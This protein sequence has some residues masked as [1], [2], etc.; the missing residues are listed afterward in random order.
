MNQNTKNKHLTLQDRI[1]IQEC[2]S[3]NISFKTIA[4]RIGKSPTT[5]SR[6]IKSH[7]QVQ[8]NSFVKTDEICPKLIKAPFVCNGCKKR[9]HSNCQFKRQV[10]IAKKAHS[11]YEYL[12]S[13]ARS[14]I[15]L[16]KES[17]YE[18]ERIISNAVKKGQ[19]VYHAIQTNN[20][21][22]ST[23]TVY[24]HIKMGYYTISSID[25]PR[26]VRFK[27]RHKK[28]AEFV[29]NCVKQGRTYQ[30][31]LDYTEKNS[32]LPI[33]QLDTVI[34][35]I[36][37]KVIMTIHF[38][39]CD[40]MTGL[41]LD[42]KTAA[43][44]TRKITDL[45]VHLEHN[46]FCFGDIIPVILTDNGGEFSN[47]LAFENDPNG[48]QETHLFYCNPNASYEKPE[49]EKNHTLLRDIVPKG[50]SFDDFTQENINMIFSHINAVK[51][52]QFNG[53]SAYDIFTFYYSAEL[54]SALG[55]SFVSPEDVI[56]SSKL[57]KNL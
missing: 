30:D 36:G 20:L 54:A 44:A 48:C 50:S 34:G 22:V 2:L 7:L 38:V 1:E 6:E 15:P 17:F 43:E 55:I 32:S 57:L 26:A 53:K 12:L 16:N 19:H 25:L 51:R 13:D 8:I 29:P 47:P 39:N 5:V 18:T 40:F 46:G 28:F 41:L 3:K 56:Q 35:N 10:Y 49:I 24:R 33:T 23:A 14:G 37:G 21:P 31:Y 9:N 4:K 11:D 45:K 42:N 27:P 52:R